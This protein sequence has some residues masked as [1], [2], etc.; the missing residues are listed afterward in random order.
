MLAS[1][2]DDHALWKQFEECTPEDGSWI[3]RC[4]GRCQ[5]C[6]KDLEVLHSL[7]LTSA[8]LRKAFQPEQCSVASAFQPC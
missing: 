1:A 7:L 6:S 8:G 5:M 3:C 4:L 2:A